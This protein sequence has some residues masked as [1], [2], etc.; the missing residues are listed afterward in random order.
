MSTIK[1]R[2]GVD[3]T[4]A[5]EIKKR[6]QE[7]TELLKKSLNDPDHYSGV[8]THQELDILEYE[9]KWDLE[10]ITTNEA[11][12]LDGIPAEVF[13]MLKMMLLKCCIQY[14]SKFGKLSS[15]HKKSIFIPI[16]NK[17]NA[18]QCSNYHTTALTL[19]TNKEM[20]KNPSS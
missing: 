2:N 5:E 19:H 7:Y 14:V 11:S 15:G 12:G 6:W 13:Q 3:L 1:D 16:P 4:E 10:H 17:A 20:L 9:F 18:K 8:V